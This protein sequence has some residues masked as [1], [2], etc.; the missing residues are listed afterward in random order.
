M[1]HFLITCSFLTIVLI[2]LHAQNFEIPKYQISISYFGE[3]LTHGGIRLGFATPISQYIKQKG[4]SQSVN[5][6]WIIG[7]YITYYKHPRNHE[8]FMFTGSIGRHRV[9]KSGFQTNLNFEAGYMLSLLDGEVYS[10]DGE[11]IIDG[12]RES[13]HIVF[14]LNGGVGW[15]FDKKLELPISFMIQPHLYFQAPYNTLIV[16]RIAMETKVVYHLT[17]KR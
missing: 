1:K 7:G 5:K 14:G 10:W 3:S 12:K 16:P 15:N 8:G 17:S 13:S 9:G 6:G 4:D 2:P 11:K